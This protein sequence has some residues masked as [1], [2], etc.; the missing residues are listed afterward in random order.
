M[1][2]I[3][4]FLLSSLLIVTRAALG[5]GAKSAAVASGPQ[6]QQLQPPAPTTAST[7]DRLISTIEKQVVEAGEAMPEDKFNF[8]PESL[9]I[10]GGEYKGVRTFAVQVKHVA[11]SNYFIW[12]PLTGDK[13]PEGLKDGNGPENLKTKADIIRFLKDSFALGHK[14]AATLT[15]ENMLQAPEHS[16]SPRLYLATFGVAHA[17]D[18]YGQMVEYLRMNGIVPPASRGKSD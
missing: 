13:L 3:G 8:S 14:A 4:I 1:K 12:S 11:A 7:L 6:A 10:A 16:K 2:Q 15:T 18:H 5:Q 17:Y 9:D